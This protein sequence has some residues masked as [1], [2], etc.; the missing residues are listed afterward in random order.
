MHLNLQSFFCVLPWSW[1]LKANTAHT[2]RPRVWHV[3]FSII[4]RP[5]LNSKE[6]DKAEE[7]LKTDQYILHF[8]WTILG[9]L[10]EANTERQSIINLL[11]PLGPIKTDKFFSPLCELDTNTFML[12]DDKHPRGCKYPEHVSHR[13]LQMILPLTQMADYQQ[14]RKCHSTI[15]HADIYCLFS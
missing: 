14:F 3:D 6:W 8:R 12:I 7:S 1:P 15:R 9:Y 5:V 10:K 13:P 4:G 2:I 11:S